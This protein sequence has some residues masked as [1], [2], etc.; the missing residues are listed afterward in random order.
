MDTSDFYYELQLVTRSMT[1]KN[2]MNTFETDTSITFAELC[3]FLNYCLSCD[4]SIISTV[5]GLTTAQYLDLST[6]SR[7]DYFWK[8]PLDLFICFVLIN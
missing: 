6:S 8:L 1:N 2:V 5:A 7:I 4:I 3:I